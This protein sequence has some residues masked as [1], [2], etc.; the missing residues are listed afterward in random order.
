MDIDKYLEMGGS[1]LVSSCEAGNVELASFLLDHGADPN[2][3]YFLGDYEALVWAI[4]GSHASLE[5]VEL[6]LARG[7]VVKGTGAL[8]AAAEHGNVGAV[9]VLLEHEGKNGDLDLEETEDYGAYDHRKL[10]DRG[11]ALYGAAADGYSEIVDILLQNGADPGF[12]DRRGRSVADVAGEKGHTD[13][14]R[15]LSSLVAEN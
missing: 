1:P 4:V 6:L 9:N 8:I 3:G 2:N 15:K 11:T 12:R 5:M 14:A 7:T 10:D 13:V